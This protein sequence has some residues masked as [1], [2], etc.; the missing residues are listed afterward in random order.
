MPGGTPHAARFGSSPWPVVEPRQTQLVGDGT[1]SSQA[2]RRGL[3]DCH[4]VELVGGPSLQRAG[5]WRAS[6]WISTN[7]PAR[8]RWTKARWVR[9]QCLTVARFQRLGTPRP[10]GGCAQRRVS[11]SSRSA[12]MAMDHRRRPRNARPCPR[13]DPT[14]TFHTPALVLAKTRRGKPGRWT[15]RR[16]LAP[17]QTLQEPCRE[18]SVAGWLRTE[19]AGVLVADPW[20][21]NRTVPVACQ[22]PSSNTSCRPTTMLS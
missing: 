10:A 21:R 19:Q 22:A 13:C 3:M 20:F 6:G 1:S 16:Q 15:P 18:K 5:A 14:L 9:Q 7:A 11:T 12:A 8:P 4:R 17:F 2:A